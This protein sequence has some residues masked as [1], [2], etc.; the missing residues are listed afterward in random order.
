VGIMVTRQSARGAKR[1]IRGAV[2]LAM[3]ALPSIAAAQ[4]SGR[5]Y[6]FGKPNASFVMRAGYS[7]ANTTAKPFE[8]ALEQTTL[9]PRSFDA[10]NLGFDFNII[11]TQHVDAVLTTDF[12]SR[13][14]TSEYKQWDEAG[15]PIMHET[16]LDRVGFGGGFRYNIFPRGRQ[17]STLAYIPAKTLPYFGATGGGMWYELVQKGDFVQV[18][19]ETSADIF[20]D[21]LRSSHYAFMGQVFTGIEQRLNA[22]WSLLGET[23]YT[24]STAKLARDYADTR[25]NI[26]LSG[27]AFNVGAAIRF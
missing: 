26:N 9:G 25:S 15:Q 24:R 11:L 1:S 12:S 23:R 5:G 7:A 6:L 4:H 19:D 21:E 22:R 8:A 14:T 13:S 2:A 17:V 3:L 16:T 10:F 27:L 20:T 18:I